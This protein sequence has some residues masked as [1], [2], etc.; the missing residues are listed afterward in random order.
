[1]THNDKNAEKLMERALS[2]AING[3]ITAPPNPWVGC[4]IV[5]EHGIV[6]EGF[7][8]AAGEPHAEINALRQAKGKTKGAT[9]YVT[10]EPCSHFGRTPP[11]SKALIDAEVSH[12]II[13][14][15]D[16]DPK[17]QGKGMEM[18]RAAG[19]HVTHGILADKISLAL[20]P[21]LHHRRTGLSYCLAKGAVSI[22]GRIAAA[23]GTSQWITSSEARLDSHY[24]RAESQAIL[25]GAGT[26]CV[27]RPRLTI[28]D[29]PIVNSTP[30][31]RVV[32]D[33]K[34]RLSPPNPLLDISLAPTVIMTTES[35]PDE[36]QQMW[37]KHGAEVAIVPKSSTHVGVDL[38]AALKIL[39][40]R[41]ILQ[42][43]VE[44][45]GTLLGAFFEAKLIQRLVL[46]VGPRILGDAGTPLFHNKAITTLSEAPELQFLESKVCGNSVRMDYTFH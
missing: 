42:V 27:D 38:H 40:D 2:L 39:G 29:I 25:V 9:V 8:K 31:L 11:C 44:G 19:I 20:A 26:A 36:V 3:R 23:D 4:V 5:N 7:H 10:L 33:A 14:I 32:L 46:Y 6:G 45:G 1:M 21:Y 12:I 22:D 34:G 43:L 15:Q 28:R 13:G 18:L 35:C 41:G 17:V 30:P 16:P 24:L 37:K